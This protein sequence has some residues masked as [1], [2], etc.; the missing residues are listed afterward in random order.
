[1]EFGEYTIAHLKNYLFEID[2]PTATVTRHAAIAKDLPGALTSDVVVT[3]DDVFYNSCASSVLI[4]IDMETLS[5]VQFIDE[6]PGLFKSARH[7]RTAWSN[8]V[9]SASRTSIPTN[10]HTLVKALRATR[11]SALDGSY[12]LQLTPD[13]RFL[14]SAHRG[15]NEVIVYSHPEL[16]EVRRI[17]FPSIQRLFP[18][19]FG[20]LDDPRLGFHHSTLSTASAAA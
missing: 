2:G 8:L 15:L 4:R 17:R 20:F 18:Q 13:G 5:K 11:W 10:T 16:K 19:H 6:K 14:L 3:A 9:E 12:G 7:L 1:M